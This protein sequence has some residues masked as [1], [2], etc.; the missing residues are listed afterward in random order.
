METQLALTYR[1]CPVHG[2]EAD[3]ELLNDGRVQRVK[4]HDKHKL[5]IQALLGLKDE[6]TLVLVLLL[7][8]AR[9]FLLLLFLSTLSAPEGLLVRADVL[10]AMELV[11]QNVLIPLCTTTIQCLVPSSPHIRQEK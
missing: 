3:V 11:E 7:R 9:L 4:V 8:I 6:T 2:R 10:V 1:S 5:V